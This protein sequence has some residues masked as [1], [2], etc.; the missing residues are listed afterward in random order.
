MSVDSPIVV[1]SETDDETVII[2]G[3]I[4]TEATKVKEAILA[5]IHQCIFC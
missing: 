2:E 4:T 1:D 5:T 3:D